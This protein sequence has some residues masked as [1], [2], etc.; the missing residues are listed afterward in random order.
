MYRCFPMTR[1][2]IYR[3]TFLPS[4]ATF[5]AWAS[6]G[7]KFVADGNDSFCDCVSV[8]YCTAWDGAGLAATTAAGIASRT[9]PT[10]DTPSN[11]VGAPKKSPHI[12]MLAHGQK[13]NPIDPSA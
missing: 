10:I 7:T 2:T 1:S 3:P 8:R 4:D 5:Q 9:Q 13:V 11:K 12:P 6:I